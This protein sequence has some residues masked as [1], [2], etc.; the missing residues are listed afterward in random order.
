MTDAEFESR[1]LAALKKAGGRVG[2]Q[3]ELAELAG[4]SASCVCR[5][6]ELLEKRGAIRRHRD[7]KRVA[8]A[9][10]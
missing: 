4:M 3:K 1:T 7:G 6:A 10:V 5:G 9:I 8:L 2:S